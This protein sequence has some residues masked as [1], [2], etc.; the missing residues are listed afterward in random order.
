MS[1]ENLLFVC[2]LH[3]SVCYWFLL[4]FGFQAKWLMESGLVP[5][6]FF[7]ERCEVS[8]KRSQR[9]FMICTVIS[10]L[11]EYG[12]VT[13]Y[14]KKED[15]Y[16]YFTMIEGRIPVGSGHDQDKGCWFEVK[17][18]SEHHTDMVKILGDIIVVLWTDF[19]LLHICFIRLHAGL[20]IGDACIKASLI[21]TLRLFCQS[22]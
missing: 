11:K 15:T 14:K 22:V 21:S 9:C 13:D 8:L 7:Q 19:H 6:R 2:S 18:G 4:V 12:C 3:N 10:W 5:L 20:V 1:Y 17:R 16:V